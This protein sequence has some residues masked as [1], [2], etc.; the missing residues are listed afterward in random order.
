MK[1]KGLQ[2]LTLLDFPEKLA[3]T[4]FLG[5]CN[6]RCPFCHNASLVRPEGEG[7]DISEEEFFSFLE[8]RR[9]RLEGVCLSGGEPTLHRELPE[10]LKKIKALG[11]AVKLDTNGYRP[12][13]LRELLSEG[14]VDYVA[15]DIKSSPESY[16]RCVGI[17]DLDLKPI[18]ESAAQ[19][20]EGKVDFEFRTTVVKELHTKEDIVSIGRWL[21]GE[22]SF[23]LQSF[24][25]SGDILCEGMSA[26]SDEEMK[27]F[28]KELKAYIPNAK[29][30][31]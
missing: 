9:G 29:W 14:L 24:K 16:G 11:F 6:F 4:V 13:V 15:M 3:C 23:F 28:E 20:M 7:E 18:Y 10:F 17:E 5:G 8:S 30:R 25:D 19:L 27:E 1:I 2:K 21:A 31:G 26:Y 12:E 22:E